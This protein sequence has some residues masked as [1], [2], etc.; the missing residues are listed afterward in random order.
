MNF[1]S[2]NL[3]NFRHCIGARGRRKNKDPSTVEHAVTNNTEK[4]MPSQIPICCG[5]FSSP[6]TER[7]HGQRLTLRILVIVLSSHCN[8]IDCIKIQI[9]VK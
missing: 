1:Y 2:I 4:L 3:L 9:N 5:A 8:K 6:A 7:D